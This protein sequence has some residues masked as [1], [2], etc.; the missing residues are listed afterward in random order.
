MADRLRF[1][2]LVPTDLSAAIS[3]YDQISDRLGTDF[4][5]AVEAR[6]DEIET[7]PDRFAI[8]FDDIRITRVK[9]FPYLILFREHQARI[10]VLGVFHSASDPQKWHRRSQDE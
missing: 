6:F 9:R 4:R 5:L 8:A 3:W 7:Q 1:H 2:P 10:Q